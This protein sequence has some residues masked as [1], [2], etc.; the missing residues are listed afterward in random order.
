[1]K[2]KIAGIGAVVTA[3]L[4]SVCCLGPI[5]LAG[6][7]L[8]GVG[9]A[10]GLAKYRSFFIGVTSVLLGVAFYLTYRKR[11][12]IC[13]D[14][15]CELRSGGRTMKIFLW[16][17]A[18]TVL[19]LATFPNWSALLVAKPAPTVSFNARQVKLAISGMHCAACAI[20]IEKSLNSVPGVKA[21]SVD[22]DNSVA[23]VHTDPGKISEEA[24]LRSVQA[25][26]PY[27]AHFIQ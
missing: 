26:G 24:I 20:N 23:I 5:V 18:V 10:A 27:S 22:F 21:A 6:L 9:L 12:T 17:V 19:V 3:S 25:A 16:G 1:M 2:E 13:E 15:K 4:A 7:G 11:K 14:G 8:G